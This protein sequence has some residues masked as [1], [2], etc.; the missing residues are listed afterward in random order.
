MIGAETGELESGI[1]QRDVA[2]SLAI[3]QTNKYTHGRER[4]RDYIGFHSFD[5]TIR[6]RLLIIHHAINARNYENTL[7]YLS[8][9]SDRHGVGSS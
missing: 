3:R 8:G 4:D 7:D 9:N 5:Q 1:S 2:L 6:R